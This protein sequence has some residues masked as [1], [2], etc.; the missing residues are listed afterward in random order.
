MQSQRYVDDF[1]LEGS[2]LFETYK[3]E[4]GDTFESL[5]HKNAYDSGRGR[6]KVNRR[7]KT[8]KTIKRRLDEVN[9][10]QKNRK[11]YQL[12]INRYN[13]GQKA[14]ELKLEDESSN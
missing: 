13:S 12:Q 8:N 11:V 6:S 10:R 7:T 3:V 1:E 2:H 14:E 9:T 4:V 5:V